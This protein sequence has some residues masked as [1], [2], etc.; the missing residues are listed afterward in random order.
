MDGEPGKGADDGAV[1]PDELQVPPGRSSMRRA[2]SLPSQRSTV[3]V[4]MRVISS[5]YVVTTCSTA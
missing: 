5:R 2:A 4:M 1:D 3:S